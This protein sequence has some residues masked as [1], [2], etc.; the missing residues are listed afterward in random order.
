MQQSISESFVDIKI[1]ASEYTRIQNF[2][3]F[4]A[5]IKLGDNKQLMVMGRL[6][7]RLL[8]FGFLLLR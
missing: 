8:H 5:G 1:A 4:E 6:C 3:Y 7:K 2:L